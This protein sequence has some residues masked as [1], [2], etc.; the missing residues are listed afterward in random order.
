MA[1][2]F[3]HPL[4][5][6]QKLEQAYAGKRVLDVAC[7]EVKFRGAI[8][9]DYNVRSYRPRECQADIVYD[10]TQFPYP[11]EDSSFELIWCSHFLEHFQDL[12]RIMEEFYR[13]LKPGGRVA[14]NTPHFSS[15]EAYRHW[16]HCHY[17]AKG[18][19][20]YFCEDSHEW[21]FYNCRYRLL[22]SK[23][24]FDDLSNCLGIG[25]LANRFSWP[26]ERRF[27][28]IFPAS[29]VYF[30]LEAIKD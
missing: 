29:S 26:Y 30:V 3:D 5:R 11:F 6:K 15:V 16:Q 2:L 9:L 19:F 25:W 8:G 13:L 20:D 14:I 17:F 24:F 1:R 12:P 4:K 18:S 21:E 27:A 22:E 23:I 7:G 28:W 10:L